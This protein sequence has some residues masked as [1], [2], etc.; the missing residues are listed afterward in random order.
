MSSHSSF[1]SPSNTRN[2]T[3]TTIINN[4]SPV[5]V[6]SP[7]TST[8]TDSASN[9]TPAA[10]TTVRPP[11]TGNPIAFDEFSAADRERIDAI[12]ADVEE[13]HTAEQQAPV[14]IAPPAMYDPRGF[15][16]SETMPNH[17]CPHCRCPMKYCHNTQFGHFLECQLV[18]KVHTTNMPL[19]E[20]HVIRIFNQHY[21]PLLRFKIFEL[22]GVLD[23]AVYEL[24][25]CIENN[26]LQASLTYLRHR[27]YHQYMQSL[28]VNG[29]PGVNDGN[30]TE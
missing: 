25:Y 2:T 21:T 6:S 22:E 26:A 9:S 24:P 1:T 27:T 14:E 12:M 7:S 3:G 15:P 13:Q 28:I 11:R 4:V 8:N 5:A 16:S 23:V 17:Y 20:H 19:L 10:A 30:T 29:H 18:N